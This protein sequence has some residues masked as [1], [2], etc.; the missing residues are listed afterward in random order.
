MCRPSKAIDAAMLASPIRIDRTIERH[1]GRLVS[2]D[3]STSGIFDEFSLERQGRLVGTAPAIVDGHA[4]M[5]LEA[6]DRIGDGATPF[7]R[8]FTIDLG[9]G[10]H[11]SIEKRT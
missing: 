3:D 8:S 2:R 11:I 10:D 6:P 5:R 4:V 9:H 1:I 7:G